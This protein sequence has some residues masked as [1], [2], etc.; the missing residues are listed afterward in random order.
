MTVRRMISFPEL[1]SE[2]LT[3]AIGPTGRDRAGGD[4]LTAVM[5]QRMRAWTRALEGLRALTWGAFEL[6]EMCRKLEGHALTHAD[7]T[8]HVGVLLGGK[9]LGAAEALM[10]CDLA[11]EYAAGNRELRALLGDSTQPTTTDEP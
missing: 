9:R 3:R 2:L 1:G 11:E 7:R 10:I 4:Y 5:A 8:G 6:L